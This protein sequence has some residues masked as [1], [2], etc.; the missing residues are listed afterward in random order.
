M[1]DWKPYTLPMIP[2][3]EE[4]MDA[5]SSAAGTL[6][7]VLDALAGL[8]E[9]LSTLV[10]VLADPLSAALSALITIIQ[11][12]VDSIAALLSSG[13]YF[14][15]DKGPYFVAAEPDG[16]QGFISRWEASF[17]DLGDQYRPQYGPEEPVSAMLFLVG[18]D[19]MESLAPALSALGTLFN[20]PALQLDEVEDY[21]APYPE[22]V[23]A[24]LST[25]PDWK[26]ET[27][28]GILPPFEKLTQVLQQTIGLLAV[29]DSYATMLEDL[30]AVIAAKAAALDGVADEIQAV[31]DDISALIAAE[32]LYVLHVEADGT[33]ALIQAVKDAGDVPP[34]SAEAYVT[35]VC[36]LGGTGDFGPVVE[37]L[38]GE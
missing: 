21:E 11:E 25:P 20:V 36:L 5:A 30:A 22:D 13:I 12:L 34:W 24:S 8:L 27:L 4:A 2:G 38:G 33:A 31:V 17:D 23:E 35:G 28:G 14:Y 19:S 10:S 32:G 7:G 3:V 15:L 18:G 6:S 16:L 37:L 26:S 1:A 9:A 29:A